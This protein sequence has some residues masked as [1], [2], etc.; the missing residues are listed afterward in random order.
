MRDIIE[1][2]SKVSYNNSD[3]LIKIAKGKYIYPSTTKIWLNKLINK[4]NK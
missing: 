3:E 1:L 2:L 4:K